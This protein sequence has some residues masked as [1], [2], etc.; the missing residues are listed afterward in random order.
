M[1]QMQPAPAR[2]NPLKWILIGCFGVFLLGGLGV[3]GCLMLIFKV[4]KAPVEASEKF[5][6]AMGAA[7]FPGAKAACDTPIAGNIEALHKS[8]PAVWGKSWSITGRNIAMN[9]GVSTAV[10]TASLNGTDNK[11]RGVELT[12][13]D[14]SGW[15]V[16]SIK[17]DGVPVGGVLEFRNINI[18]K[19][20]TAEGWEAV[21]KFEVHGLRFEPRGEKKRIAATEGVV[22]RG[23]DGKELL[24]NPDFK[25]LDDA[26]PD[27]VAIFTNTFTIPEAIAKGTFV[28]HTTVKDHIGG[29]TVEK[30]IEFS[31]P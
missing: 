13:V 7:D 3:G 20:K 19:T 16:T 14:H 21:V 9:N 23:P 6:T 15:K 11:T 10:V 12:L 25:T 1:A 4:T 30:D 24:K 28:V 27:P 2:S 26:A 22:V 18:T 29:A 31:L 8:D 5:L 17:V